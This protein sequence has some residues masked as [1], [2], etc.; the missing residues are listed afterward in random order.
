MAAYE[1]NRLA[2]IE[3]LIERDVFASAIVKFMERSTAYHGTASNLLKLLSQKEDDGT[4]RS[5][6]WPQS[7][8]QLSRRLH[9]LVASLQQIGIEVEWT[10]EGH[11]RLRMIALRRGAGGPR[12]SIPDQARSEELRR[13]DDDS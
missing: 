5:R 11:D 4:R 9:K 2:G 6:D 10:R 12:S 13:S 1:N 8:S 7:H 3:R